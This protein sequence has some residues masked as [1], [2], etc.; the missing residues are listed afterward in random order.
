MLHEL[1][2]VISVI[3][4]SNGVNKKYVVLRNVMEIFFINITNIF[5]TPNLFEISCIDSPFLL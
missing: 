5:G 3:F 1:T 4:I 2:I